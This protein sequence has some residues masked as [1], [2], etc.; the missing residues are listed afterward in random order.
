VPTRDSAPLGAPVWIELSTSDPQRAKDF[1]PQLFGWTFEDLG[2]DFGNYVGF[3]KDGV[4]V[5]GMMKNPQPG[6]PDSW[7]TYLASDDAKATAGAVV[8]G[9]GKVLL[10]PIDVMSLGTMAVVSDPS[11]AVVGIWQPGAHKGFGVVGEAGA[12]VWHELHSRDYVV[13]VP[14]YEEVFGWQTSTMSDTDEF[15]YTVMVTDGQQY[16][17]LMDSA[18][19]LPPGV[20]SNW[21]IYFGAEDVDATL[22]RAVELGGTVTQPA[23]D[24]PYGRLA[25]VADP[26]GALFKLSSLSS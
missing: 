23:E 18:S 15:R 20:P 22:A 13:A 8:A 26:T 9:G 3:D 24:T 19:F 1:Y 4:A 21:Q 14:F 6:A 2:E 12:P 7:T 25:Q 11:G 17:G 5:A 10:E 16:A